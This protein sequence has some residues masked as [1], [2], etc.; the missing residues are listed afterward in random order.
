MNNFTKTSLALILI[1]GGG[2]YSQIIEFDHYLHV[3]E[4]E[5]KCSKCHKNKLIKNS[6]HA[7]DN[8]LPKEAYCTKKCHKIWRD[9]EECEIC[10]LENPPYET[11]PRRKVN[12]DF[13]HKTHAVDQRLPCETCHGTFEEEGA[14]PLIPSMTDCISCHEEK[15]ARTSC[16]TCHEHPEELRP[17]GHTPFWLTEH[18]IAALSN[19]EDCSFCHTEGSCNNCHAGGTLTQDKLSAMN[20]FPSFRPDDTHTT[21]TLVRSHDL[22]YEFFHGLDAKTQARDCQVCHQTDFCSDCHQNADD[23]LLNK[24]DFHGGLDWGAVR[25]PSGTDFADIT[26]GTHAEMARRDIEACQACHDVE[27]GDPICLQCHLDADGMKGTDP[28]THTTGFMNNIRGDWCDQ[29]I[30]LCYTCHSFTFQKGDGFCGY[31]H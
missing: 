18:K 28:K 11:F 8:L 15:L 9:E 22:N 12:F 1:W 19:Q 30:S 7:S 10:H 2:L 24:P 27:G 6:L 13:S 20:P 31:C 23:F 21:M 25:Y 16:L 5:I 4:T 26:G 17:K 14:I 3:E 29:E